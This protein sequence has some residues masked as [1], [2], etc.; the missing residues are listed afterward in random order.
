MA[1]AAE[2]AVAKAGTDPADWLPVYLT[3]VKSN[4]RLVEPSLQI[5]P[6]ESMH[7]M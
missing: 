7:A 6:A 1:E 3:T 4:R 2:Q 5:Q